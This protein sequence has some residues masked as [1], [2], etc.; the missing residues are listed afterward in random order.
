MGNP[1]AGARIA[2]VVSVVPEAHACNLIYLDDLSRVPLVQIMAGVSTDTG[3]VD[4]PDPTP[5]ADPTLPQRPTKQ[6]DL[7]AVVMPVNGIPLVWGF[8]PPQVSQLLFQ[9]RANFRVNRHASDVYST[10]EDD[11]SFTMAWPNGTFLK[12]SQTPAKEDLT[13]KDFDKKWAISRNKGVA[14]YVNLVVADGSG[15]QKAQLEID[16]AGNMTQTLS[17]NLTQTVQGNLTQTVSGNA[18]VNVSGSITST[19]QGWTHNGPLTLNGTLDVK[20][21]VTLENGAAITGNATATG[22]ITGATDVVGGGKSLK[23]HDHNVVNVQSGGSTITT[24]PPL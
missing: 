3:H 1:F 23:G 16:P 18:T 17:G 9:G 24:S 2:K 11:G 22:T 14:P 8:L 12:V 13:G 6:R 7:Y 10:L 4:L 21:S 19:A 15:N 20:Q 5:P